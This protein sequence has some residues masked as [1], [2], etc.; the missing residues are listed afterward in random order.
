MLT[1]Q[2]PTTPGREGPPA[3]KGDNGNNTL[4]D[5]LA[6]FSTA[7]ALVGVIIAIAKALVILRSNC[8]GVEHTASFTAASHDPLL[9]TGRTSCGLLKAPIS[10]NQQQVKISCL[11][12]PCAEDGLP[13]TKVRACISSSCQYISTIS[14]ET[15]ARRV[16]VP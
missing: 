1:T 5:M 6:I 12:A 4:V 15:L 9:F 2:P 13:T 8:E 11:A 10:Y 14:S 3:R 16:L 7:I